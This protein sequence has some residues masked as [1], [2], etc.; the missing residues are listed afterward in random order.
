MDESH[1][2]HL[3]ILR[4]FI[5][6]YEKDYTAMMNIFYD[7][8]MNIEWIAVVIK[9]K[10]KNIC[11]RS[12]VNCTKIMLSPKLRDSRRRKENTSASNFRKKKTNESK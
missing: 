7:S 3:R 8:M 11:L 5:S 12:A 1:Q 6:K 10:K 9:K 4:D 2:I